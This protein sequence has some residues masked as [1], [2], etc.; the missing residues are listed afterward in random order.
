MMWNVVLIR[1]AA[2]LRNDQRFALRG[3]DGEA[4]GE[5]LRDLFHWSDVSSLAL[6]H[7]GAST[8]RVSKP[9]PLEPST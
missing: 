8:S 2:D 1:V 6:E 5:A 3:L 9:S 4:D 7:K